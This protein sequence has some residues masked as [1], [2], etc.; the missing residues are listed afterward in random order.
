M[1]ETIR[2]YAAGLPA[3]DALAEVRARHA[4]FFVALAEQANLTTDAE[5]PMDHQLV[6]PEHDNIRV[7]LEWS[8]EDGQLDV[9]LRLAVALEGF[10]AIADPLEGIRW[11]E[12]LLAVPDSGRGSLAGLAL[13]VY[14]VLISIAGDFERAERLWQESLAEFLDAGDD[15][16]AASCLHHLAMC[17]GRRGDYVTARELAEQCLALSERAGSRKVEAQ[18]RGLIAKHALLAGEHERGLALLEEA[19]ALSRD[20]GFP[21]W[22]KN[23]LCYL[24]EWLLEHG[25]PNGAKAAAYEALQIATRIGDRVG[26]IDALAILAHTASAQAQPKL[27]GRLWGAIEAEATRAPFPGWQRTRRLHAGAIIPASHEF[28]TARRAGTRLTL[29][30]AVDEAFEQCMDQR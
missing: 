1:H 9:G 16:G 15:R 30:T 3:G 11:F 27:A 22:E 2:E 17:A 26:Q 5:G 14:G 28:E 4:G 10:W 25:R 13:R 29:K 19:I 24:A 21:W 12:R 6:V 8:L 7:A 18:A 20:A 23:E